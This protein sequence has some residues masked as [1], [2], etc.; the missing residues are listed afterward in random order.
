MKRIRRLIATNSRRR[1]VGFVIASMRP[2]IPA[3]NKPAY[4]WRHIM[5]S[6]FNMTEIPPSGPTG[7]KRSISKSLAPHAKKPRSN[8]YLQVG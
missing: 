8:G 1:F 2:P 6:K 4:A 3:A 5:P 7:A